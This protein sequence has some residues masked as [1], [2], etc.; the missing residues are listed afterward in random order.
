MSQ[1]NLPNEKGSD[2]IPYISLIQL[3]NKRDT[4]NSR[5]LWPKARLL[6]LQL[7]KFLKETIKKAVTTTV[8]NGNRP[9]DFVS[10]RSLLMHKKINGG[11][12]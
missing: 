8:N 10:L 7:T 9:Y 1:Y 5:Y 11:E 6:F 12:M 2:T 4:Q 3:I